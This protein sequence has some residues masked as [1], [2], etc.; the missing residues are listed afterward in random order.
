MNF[1]AGPLFFYG[2]SGNGV[3]RK[4]SFLSFSFSFVSKDFCLIFLGGFC[5]FRGIPTTKI[6]EKDRTSIM[7]MGIKCHGSPFT[8]MILFIPVLS[9][10]LFFP[11]FFFSFLTLLHCSSVYT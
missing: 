4:F 2:Q 5:S 1:P 3:V 9:F 6:K 8:K 10:F 11:S 7:Q